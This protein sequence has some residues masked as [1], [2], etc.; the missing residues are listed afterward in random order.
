MT[1][2]HPSPACSLRLTMSPSL[3]RPHVTSRRATPGPRAARPGGQGLRRPP[4]SR[5]LRPRTTLRDHAPPS[6]R[7]LSRHRTRAQAQDNRPCTPG[8]CQGQGRVRPGDG[9]RAL[10]ALE[11]RRTTAAHG[12]ANAPVLAGSRAQGQAQPR[13]ARCGAQTA[14]APLKQAPVRHPGVHARLP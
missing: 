1:I 11:R 3:P 14:H 7:A 13:A 4:P 12:V 6:S 5:P 8:A 10:W 2:L 9:I